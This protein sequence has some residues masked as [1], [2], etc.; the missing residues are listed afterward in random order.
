MMHETQFRVLALAAVGLA[1]CIAYVNT[2]DGGWVW[3]DASSVLLHK[4]VQDPSKIFQL[5]REDQHAF[6]RGS[7]NFYRPLVSVSFMV[8]FLLSGA[9]N[10]SVSG[11]YPDIPPLLFH[12]TNLLWHL[13]AAMV[14]FALLTRLGA[15]Q[16]VR[17][18]VVVLYVLH[19]LHTEAVAYISGRADMMSAAFMFAG[20]CLVLQEGK[21]KKRWIAIGLGMLCFCGGLLSKESSTIFP[22]LLAIIL[23]LPIMGETDSVSRKAMLKHRGVPLAL[24]GG[25]L[26]VY[27][28]FRMTVLKFSE[29]GA[30]QVSG[31]GQRLVETGQAFFFYLVKLFIPT[32]L[33]MEQTLAGV[34]V[35]HAAAGWLGLAACVV[36]LIVAAKRQQF[37][38]ALGLAWFLAAWLPISGI[39]PLNAPMAEHWMYVPMAGFWW[40]LAEAVY[41]AVQ[42]PWARRLALA[43]AA[44]LALVFLALTIQRNE[45]WHDNER[46]FVSTLKENSNTLRVRYN[47]AVAYEDILKNW[48]AARREYE[49]VL[50]LYGEQKRPAKGDKAAYLLP[51]EV[52]VHLSLG[53]LGI[54]EGAYNRA[55]KHFS[56]VAAVQK[57]AEYRA[58]CTVAEIGMGKCFLALGEVSEANTWFM[59]AIT[60]DPSCALEV[61]ALMTGRPVQQE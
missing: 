33:H 30:T 43:G 35:W 5:F 37:R 29:A 32:H 9:K 45:D 40:A 42:G 13:G 48:P 59:K 58:Q 10:T 25:I 18:V 1:G 14:L 38:I 15:P 51:E 6:G 24:S 17:A 49:Y 53:R 16:G 52:D 60:L 56:M 7:G 36:F 57:A 47:L 22:V 8:D 46:L 31:L 21:A 50:G 19:P 28:I 39:F 27:A 3:D 61:D 11:S 54:R 12:M 23:L 41:L 4:H 26:L 34:P 2:F 44:G 55:M 20:L